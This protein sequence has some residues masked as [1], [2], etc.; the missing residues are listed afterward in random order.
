M[1]ATYAVSW[2]ERPGD[3]SSGKLE[4]RPR[5]IAFEG[6]NGTGSRSAEV[7]YREIS[8]IRIARVPAERIAGRPT[9]V[10]ERRG[11]PPI[12][13][14]SVAEAGIV[15]ELAEHLAR[16]HLGEELA[17][18]RALVVVPLKPGTRERVKAL[19]RAG[20]PFDPYSGGLDR[21]HVFLTE[22]EA[23]FVFEGATPDA[24]Q[25]I[26]ETASVWSAAPDWADLAA[27]PPRVAE[28][29]Y[30]WVRPEVP[31]N[32]LYTATPGPGDSDGGD[33]Y[34]P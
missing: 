10:V 1:R 26:V 18:S 19:V 16:L 28:D 31:E 32:V 23:V 9:L 17:V 12:R 4:L 20:P 2:Q 15:S 24:I 14:A 11:A 3:M 22:Q 5:G 13:I 27:G 8:A 34:A 30:D 29:V 33:L 25:R 7:E 6:S 21:H